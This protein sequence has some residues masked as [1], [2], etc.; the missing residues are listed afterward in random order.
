MWPDAK[1]NGIGWF[2]LPWILG[3]GYL[4]GQPEFWYIGGSESAIGCGKYFF[5]QRAKVM[6]T[7]LNLNSFMQEECISW[8]T[9]SQTTWAI[10]D[11]EIA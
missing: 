11:V 8:S 9:S 10:S 2:E 3:A 4:S 5:S 6:D 7:G 1:L